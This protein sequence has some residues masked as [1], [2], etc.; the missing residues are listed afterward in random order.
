MVGKTLEIGSQELLV[1]GPLYNKIDK[2]DLLEEVAKD[3]LVVLLG[4]IS[5]PYNTFN[6]VSDR[7]KKIRSFIAGK[8]CFYILGD[9]DLIF[10]KKI[11]SSNADTYDW[12]SL[13]RKALRFSF[14]NNTNLL[15][16]HG[17]VLPTHTTWN[18]VQDDYESAFV[19]TLVDTGVSWHTQYDGR[20]G[21]VLSSHGNFGDSEI[22][23]YN[24]SAALDTECYKTDKLAVQIFGPN[25][26]GKTLYV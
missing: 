7:L 14:S 1:I 4:D 5:Y 18:D 24:H 9:K 10:M 13:Q 16:V 20:F 6:D 12:L 17:G 8:R 21:Y 3:K 25:G 2:L 26:L 23:F 22:K 15:V 11:F 19:S